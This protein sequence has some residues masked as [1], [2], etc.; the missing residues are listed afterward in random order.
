MKGVVMRLIS[1]P[2]KLPS[3]P[4]NYRPI[5]LLEVPKKMLERVVWR[6][7]GDYLEQEGFLNVAQETGDSPCHSHGH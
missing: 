1:K 3:C 7:L 5:S 4:E 6:R 2:G